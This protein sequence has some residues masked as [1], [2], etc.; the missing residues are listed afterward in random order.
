[1][2]ISLSGW[3]TQVPTVILF[4][5]GKE[6]RRLPHSAAASKNKTFMSRVCLSFDSRHFERSSGALSDVFR[7]S[8][9][10]SSE[11]VI[12]TSI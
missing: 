9:E 8:E 6:Q 10:H 11:I 2:Q 4:E 5:S 3:D 1:M 12:T 7:D